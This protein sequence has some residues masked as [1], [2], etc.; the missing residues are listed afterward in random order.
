MCP[1]LIFCYTKIISIT[2]VNENGS[3]E[4]LFLNVLKNSSV[5]FLNILYLGNVLK[6]FLLNVPLIPKVCALILEFR[7][8][9]TVRKTKKGFIVML[10]L[11]KSK[12]EL[13]LQKKY[14]EQFYK[15]L[16]KQ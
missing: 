11:R 6:C 13:K 12:K 5:Q 9:N 14:R 1:K 3:Q 15:Y 8:E 4:K 2:G 10:F 7:Q 16:N